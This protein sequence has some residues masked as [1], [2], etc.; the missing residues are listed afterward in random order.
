M[1]ARCDRPHLAV[2]HGARVVEQNAPHPRVG[3]VRSPHEVVVDGGAKSTRALPGQNEPATTG[4]LQELRF[5]GM[6]LGVDAR[7]G[8]CVTHVSTEG[9]VATTRS[10]TRRRLLCPACVR[11]AACQYLRQPLGGAV[12]GPGSKRESHALHL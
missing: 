7:V 1:A 4:A 3:V 12:A 6:G 11:C 10:M 9:N 5:H 2:E 8:T